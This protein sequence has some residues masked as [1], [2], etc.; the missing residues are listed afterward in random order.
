[1][2][3]NNGKIKDICK[4]AKEK[5][6]QEDI[7]DFRKCAV[8]GKCAGSCSPEIR[9]RMDLAPWKIVYLLTLEDEKIESALASETIQLCVDCS[10][11][12]SRCPM[13]I[14]IPKIMEL[15][16]TVVIKHKGDFLDIKEI[17]DNILE[18]MPQMGIIDACKKFSR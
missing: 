12:V 6:E 7:G 10:A 2:T 13:K 1:M 9:A 8:C 15:L 3:K 18:E 14:N 5:I 11:C 4:E 16:R 17:S